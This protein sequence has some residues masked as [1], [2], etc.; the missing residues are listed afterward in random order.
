MAPGPAQILLNGLGHG[1]GCDDDTTVP[2]RK[3]AQKSQAAARIA[4]GLRKRYCQHWRQPA[5]RLMKN[6]MKNISTK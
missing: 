3:G 1:A 2:Q 6:E 4:S 5:F